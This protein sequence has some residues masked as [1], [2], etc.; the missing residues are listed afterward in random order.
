LLPYTPVFRSR[1]AA[2]A[3]GDG[4]C[5]FG[6]TRDQ[7]T[8]MGRPAGAEMTPAQ[9]PTGFPRTTLS[10]SPRHRLHS[11]SHDTTGARR[12]PPWHS[13]G[14]RKSTRLNSATGTRSR[15]TLRD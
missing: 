15:L 13:S 14:D 11:T 6:Y 8:P 10:P 3:A 9:A 1:D 7:R 5:R 12:D 4:G 2:E